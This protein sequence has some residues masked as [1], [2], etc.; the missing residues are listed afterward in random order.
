MDE[1]GL[2]TQFSLV[3]GDNTASWNMFAE[4]GYIRPTV[5]RSLFIGGALSLFSL[6]GIEFSYIAMAMVAGITALR[7]VVAYPIARGSGPVRFDTPQGGTPLS[8]LLALVFGAWWPTCGFF[9]PQ[10][11]IWRD[12]EFA[13]YSGMQ[14]FATWMSMVLVY[15][16]ASLFYPATFNAGPE[17]FLD[18]IGVVL[19]LSVI[20]VF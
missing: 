6:R 20:V 3:R 17:V 18:T 13:R 2:K 1:R 7:M 16:G 9:V 5:L 4:S 12:R 11:D 19:S 15:A 14:A 8:V 10:E